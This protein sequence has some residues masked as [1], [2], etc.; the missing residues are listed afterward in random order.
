MYLL[1]FIFVLRVGFLK[2][3]IICM[4]KVFYLSTKGIKN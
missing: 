2:K 4:A 3:S 1:I